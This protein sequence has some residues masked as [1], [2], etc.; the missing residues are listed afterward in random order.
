MIIV[1]KS[2]AALAMIFDAISS[3]A[4][5][6]ISEKITI[7]NNKNIDEKFSYMDFPVNEIS[8]PPE[9]YSSLFVL[10]A[11]TP[12]TKKELYSLFSKYP[13]FSVKNSSA[14]ISPNSTSKSGCLIDAN[15]SV[16]SGA[17]LG[18]FVTLYT[19]CS[20]A[21][22]CRIGDFVTVCPNASVCGDVIIGEGSFI[23]AGAVIKNGIKIGSE[24]IIG[25]GAVVVNDVS[26]GVTVFGNPAKPR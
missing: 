23:G 13:Y 9:D 21:H 5:G 17:R 24:C 22:D 18:R 4:M 10:G 3:G 6:N 7:L 11:V 15:V 8:N 19:N 20:I 12:R 2:R 1:G 16:A 14:F 25:A 26:D